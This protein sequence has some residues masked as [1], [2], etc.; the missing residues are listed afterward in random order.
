M[1]EHSNINRLNSIQYQKSV[2]NTPIPYIIQLPQDIHNKISHNIS[3][4][5][6]NNIQQEQNSIKDGK[7]E[8]KVNKNNNYQ[9]SGNGLVNNHHCMVNKN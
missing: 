2:P 1:D 4:I 3:N 8:I 5:N 7:E 6:N 9:I